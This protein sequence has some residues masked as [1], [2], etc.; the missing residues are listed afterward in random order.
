MSDDAPKRRRSRTAPVRA[1]PRPRV[2][3]EPVL[4]S[5][6]E[7]VPAKGTKGRGGGPHGEAWHVK[8]DGASA[9]VVFTNW[10]DEPPVGPHASIQIFINKA[11][12]RRGIGRV[13]YRMACEASRHGVIYASMRKS[14]LASRRAA[15]EAGFV[16][17]RY[18][19]HHQLL[20]VWRRPGLAEPA[21]G[22]PLTGVPTP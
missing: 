16:E 1:K 20:M 22:E 3:R 15:Q 13:A 10:V 5:K 2:T 7:L 8:A 11:S 17:V 12:Q 21:S 14:N 6:V 18:P 19:D 4:A 9:G